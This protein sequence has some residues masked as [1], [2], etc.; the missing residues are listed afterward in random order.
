MPNLNEIALITLSRTDLIDHLPEG[1]LINDVDLD[2]LADLMKDSLM[3]VFWVAM[4]AALDVMDFTEAGNDEE[5]DHSLCPA[6]GWTLDPMLGC[7]N[8]K[9]TAFGVKE[10]I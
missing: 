4:D 9:C 8:P 3:D 10:N 7:R 5:D 1:V 6:C 2:R